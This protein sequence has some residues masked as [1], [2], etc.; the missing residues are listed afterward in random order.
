MRQ[1]TGRGYSRWV[2]GWGKGK[3]E[4]RRGSHI[5]KKRGIILTNNIS[6]TVWKY[7]EGFV[8]LCS[9]FWR[10]FFKVADCF[11]LQNTC[12]MCHAKMS[13]RAVVLIL[14]VRCETYIRF[15]P[16]LFTPI[17]TPSLSLPCTHGPVKMTTLNS[18]LK[19]P[20][21]R[22][23]FNSVSI[24][25]SYCLYTLPPGF[26]QHYLSNPLPLPSI[27][28]FLLPSQ[29]QNSSPKEFFFIGCSKHGL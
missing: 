15:C 16:S 13:L 25:C 4:R 20:T 22:F 12:E 17:Q 8:I 23:P 5:S 28:S 18:P 21:H 6:G 14:L 26:F 10:R 1:Q 29:P 2:R 3:G 24:R 7:S 11:I 27:S 19:R 9:I